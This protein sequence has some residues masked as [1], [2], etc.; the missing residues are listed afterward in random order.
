MRLTDY[1]IKA[2]KEI[3]AKIFGDDSIA[4]IFGSRVDDAKKGGDI[5]IYIETDK[6]AD[7]F[8][9]KLKFLVELEKKIGERKIDVVIKS[10][11]SD[12]N[13]PIYKIAKTQGVLLK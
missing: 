3:S 2:I 6:N 10:A 11:D 4:Y 1:E 9:N 5:D 13:L 12:E 7:I 8:E